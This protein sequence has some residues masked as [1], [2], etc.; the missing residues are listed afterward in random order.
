[1]IITVHIV[2]VIMTT[3]II[4]TAVL[5][6]AVL[7]CAVLCCAVLCCA[8]LC[9][10]V[11][12]C[13]VLCCA[14]SYYAMLCYA[15]LCYA[16]LC[17]AMLCYTMLYYT[18]TGWPG[19]CDRDCTPSISVSLGVASISEPALRAAGSARAVLQRRSAR[20]R[21][22]RHLRQRLE[23]S[24][25][26]LCTC[27]YVDAL[28]IMLL[29]LLHRVHNCPEE[30]ESGEGGKPQSSSKHSKRLNMVYNKLILSSIL[31][32][33]NRVQRVCKDKCA[34]TGAMRKEVGQ[35]GTPSRVPRPR[36]TS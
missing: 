3:I 10:A 21:A 5:C 26:I 20:A 36:M 22:I 23:H 31:V 14:I 18:I 33:S 8:V 29:P 28:R 19:A 6:C 17:Y 27:L 34:L 32:V 15:M 25:R 35:P 11:L 7:C 2:I 13:A 16:M 1:M 24:M 4:M 9:C 12:C 30:G